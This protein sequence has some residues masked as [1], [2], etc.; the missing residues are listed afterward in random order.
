MPRQQ[1]V[2]REDVTE[3]GKLVGTRYISKSGESFIAFTNEVPESVRDHAINKGVR[4]STTDAAAGIKDAAQAYSAMKARWEKIKSGDWSGGRGPGMVLEAIANVMS[5]DVDKVRE[6]WEAK[7][8]AE[9]KKLKAH[10]QVKLEI[11]RIQQERLQS[12][13]NEAEDLE[14]LL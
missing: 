4:E 1:L 8:E 13:A 10:P 7:T 9:Q 12:Q 14:N 6:L 11:A 5:L 2:K 3:S